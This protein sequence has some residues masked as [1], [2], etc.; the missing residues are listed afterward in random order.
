MA[1][2]SDIAGSGSRTRDCHIGVLIESYFLSRRS[3]DNSS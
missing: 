1:G 2:A 3:E